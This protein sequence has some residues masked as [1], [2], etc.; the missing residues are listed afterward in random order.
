MEAAF[1]SSK[2]LGAPDSIADSPWVIMKFGGTSV[3]SAENWSTIAALVRNRLDEGLRPVV[4][5]SALEGVSAALAALLEAAVNGDIGDG[6]TAIRE[7]HYELAGDLGLD[8]D[9]L[10]AEHLDELEQLVSGVRLVREV[11]V[12]VRVRVMALGELMAT[13]LGAGLPGRKRLAGALDGRP[14]D[15]DEFEPCKPRTASR[16][17][18]GHLR[19]RSRPRRCRSSYGRSAESS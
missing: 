7:R 18:V 15:A 16:L 4:V 9:E 11:S 12:R 6:F 2:A 19:P 3:S 13:R 10:L 17:P 5:H 1:E 8:A 14:Q